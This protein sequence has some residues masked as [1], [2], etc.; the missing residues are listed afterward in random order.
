MDL[1]SAHASFRVRAFCLQKLKK[2]QFRSEPIVCLSVLA[3]HRRPVTNSQ[4]NIR[5]AGTFWAS[6]VSIIMRWWKNEHDI[7]ANYPPRIVK[8]VV[9]EGLISCR[10][11]LGS[12][13]PFDLCMHPQ[14]R[15]I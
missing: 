1:F 2:Y 12:E 8:A 3:D 5:D 7:S 15:E 4:E 13:L 11:R 14:L 9:L 10:R 6:M